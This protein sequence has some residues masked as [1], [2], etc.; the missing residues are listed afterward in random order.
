MVPYAQMEQQRTGIPASVT[1]AQLI[2]ETGWGSSLLATKYNNAFGIKAN[3]GWT[4]K[5]S[6]PLKDH[7]EGS[8]VPYRAYNS[9]AES[10]ADHSNFLIENKR[11]KNAFNYKND[12]IQFI[13]EV[14]N[15]GYAMDANDYQNSLIGLVKSNNLTQ[16]D[17]NSG[18]M[19]TFPEALKPKYPSSQTVTENT[20]GVINPSTGKI[21]KFDQSTGTPTPTI[22]SMFSQYTLANVLW[23]LVGLVL[24]ALGLWVAFNPAT[25][26]LSGVKDIMNAVG[27]QAFKKRVKKSA[28]KDE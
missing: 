15:A 4:G 9:I 3:K 26:A 17:K 12:P 2:Q 11:Y 19:L 20:T 28:K 8:N 16:Y 7:V 1:L 22:E 18:T 10:F 25:S 27:K 13:R 5:V 14:A 21:D 24:I 23:G 6:P